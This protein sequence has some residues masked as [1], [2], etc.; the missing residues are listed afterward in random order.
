MNS[1]LAEYIL[2]TDRRV[3]LLEMIEVTHPNFSRDYRIV[4]NAATGL[5]VTHQDGLDYEYQYA[6]IKIDFHNSRTN[7]DFGFKATIGDLGD[8]IAIELDNLNAADSFSQKPLV[9]YRAYR[10]DDLS[11]PIYGPLTLEL[12]DLSSNSKGWSFD[13]KAPVINKAGTGVAYTLSEQPM[14]KGFL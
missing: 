14:M 2:A 5:T 9:V 7:L 13:A 1:D 10:S 12:Q 3:I 4:R 11:A 6:P 8:L